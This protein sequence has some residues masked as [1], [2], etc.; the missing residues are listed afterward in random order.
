MFDYDAF[1]IILPRLSFFPPVMD[2]SQTRNVDA[3]M[4]YII[5]GLLT[6]YFSKNMIV[7]LLVAMIGTNLL[8][9]LHYQYIVLLGHWLNGP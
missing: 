2:V 6:S 7:V 9:A 8:V 4:F 3:V 5:L 1:K